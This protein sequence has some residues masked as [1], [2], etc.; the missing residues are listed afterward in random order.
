MGKP[1]ATVD[2]QSLELTILGIGN[3]QVSLRVAIQAS[4]AAAGDFLL[5]AVRANLSYRD[6]TLQDLARLDHPYARRHGALTLHAGPA[7]LLADGRH[8][9]HS[10]TG[11]L[12]A[13]LR[14]RVRTTTQQLTRGGR[15]TSGGRVWY[16]VSVDDAAAPH[17]EYLTHGTRTM[18]P[19]DPLE[20][21][22]LSPAVQQEMRRRVV[23]VL[24][25]TL[26][27][28]ASIRFGPVPRRGLR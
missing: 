14:G 27:A 16:E 9:V 12:V 18:L 13:A 11:R 28:Q 22:E 24:G 26:R 1:V 4:T 21:T 3:A 20:Q 7:A 6:H 10:H 5:R 23:Q 2:K 19:R 8:A 25:K 15:A 17:W